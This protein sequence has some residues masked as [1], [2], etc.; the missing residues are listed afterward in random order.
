METRVTETAPDTY[1][2]TTVV[3]DSPMAFNQYLVAADE[4]T[5]FHTGMRFLFPLV[6]EESPTWP[7]WTLPHPAS[8]TNNSA[9]SL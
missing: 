1:Q 2:L 6:S 9:A 4:A 7:S 3:P 5:L 8:L